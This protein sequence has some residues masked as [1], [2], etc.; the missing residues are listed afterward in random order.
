[1]TRIEL[2]RCGCCP[3]HYDP[4]L[5]S[6]ARC[7]FTYDADAWARHC[8]VSAMIESPEED[9]LPGQWLLPGVTVKERTAEE[10]PAGVARGHVLFALW[11]AVQLQAGPRGVLSPDMPGSVTHQGLSAIH[12]MLG[13]WG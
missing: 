3:E 8:R 9:A 4:E 2:A 1:M 5:G 7:W 11:G 13:F 6:C 12:N 10:P